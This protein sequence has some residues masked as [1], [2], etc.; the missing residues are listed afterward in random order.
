MRNSELGVSG[1]SFQIGLEWESKGMGCETAARHDKPR[2]LIF[3]SDGTL[4]SCAPGEE[5]N[6]GLIFRLMAEQGQRREQ[7]FLY[8]PGVQG[9]G[10][11]RWWN[12][13]TGITINR[14]IKHGY[15]F[16]ASRYRPG[17]RIFLFG[18]SRGAYAVRSLAG[19]IGQVG[20]LRQ[21]HATARNLRIAFRLY[22]DE[23]RARAAALFKRRR[24]HGAVP[25]RMLGVFDTV[26][27][28]GLP[29]PI[30][31]RLAAMA[32]EFHDHRLG[33]HIEHGYH[34]LA[35]DEDRTAY[36]PLLW[37]KSEDWEGRLEQAWFPGS[38]ADI[39]GETRSRPGARGLSNIVLNWMLRRAHRHGL[40]LPPGWERRFPEDPAAP[41]VG[42]R[43]GI[44]R[45]FLLRT[46]RKTGGGD[47]EVLHLSIRDR[48]QRLPQYR[49]RGILT[50]PS[51][52]KPE[53]DRA[54][55][56]PDGAEPA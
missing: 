10:W 16:L 24:C 48:Q 43:T 4:S 30:L 56:V 34:A 29:Y 9:S 37:E 46:P 17:D 15:A 44:A 19:M 40:D 2:N 26:K 27:S 47:G 36:R 12:A 25:I 23:G 22:E 28:L 18:Y 11:S 6:A 42:A 21:N 20:L 1:P 52:A 41:S 35:L 7:M 32:T 14:S 45:A 3:I 38:H 8:D 55:S 5:T 13:A 53:Q 31:S 33:H 51:S 39:G 50:L 49:P 54:S